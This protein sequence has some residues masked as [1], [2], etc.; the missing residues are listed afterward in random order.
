MCIYRSNTKEFQISKS[1]SVQKT[2]YVLVI[3]IKTG[4]AIRTWPSKDDTGRILQFI[5]LFMACGEAKISKELLGHRFEYLTLDASIPPNIKSKNNDISKKR[6][7]QVLAL[8][9]VFPEIDLD[10]RQL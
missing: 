8:L 10:D 5:S 6:E 2:V 1:R 3:V 4:K 9:E 7:K